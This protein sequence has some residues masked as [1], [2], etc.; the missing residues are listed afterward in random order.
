MA[1]VE[2][3]AAQQPGQPA[4]PAGSQ[5]IWLTVWLHNHPARAFYQRRRYVDVGP[6]VFEFEGESYENRLLAKALPMR[7]EPRDM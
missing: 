5:M 3:Q 2:Q 6:T 4:E 1:H 7:R